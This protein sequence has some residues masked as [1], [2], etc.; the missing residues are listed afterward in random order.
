MWTLTGI[1]VCATFYRCVAPL[2]SRRR[3]QSSGVDFN[4]LPSLR[5][6]LLRI[7][8]E[9]WLMRASVGD[10]SRKTVHVFKGSICVHEKPDAT[11]KKEIEVRRTAKTPTRLLGR[12]DGPV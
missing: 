6:G 12:Q 10:F 8:S 4:G 7:F 1:S 9:G 5:E 11:G 3:F 2:P